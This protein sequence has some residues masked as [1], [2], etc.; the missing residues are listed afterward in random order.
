M[1][2]I[3]PEGAT[4]LEQEELKDLIP[5]H[6]TTQEELNAWEER[7][8]L[9]AQQWAF[10]K[11]QNIIS[12]EFI[13]NLHKHMF[14]K[15]W[16]WAGKFR[17]SEKNIDIS[18]YAI[19]TKIK[20]LCDDI[21]YYLEHKTYSKDEIAIRFHHRLVW[22]HAFPNGNG[23]HARL[24]ADLLIVKQGNPRFTWG[25]NQNLYKASPVR[26]QYIDALQLADRGDYS[27]LII[28]A[29]S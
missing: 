8:I 12:I 24:I 17:H 25:M 14:N 7:N 27:K 26:A 20:E 13:K 22:I 15:T 5:I 18:W 9:N 21:E 2:F 23:R 4:P 11:K 29:R 3:F 1:K 28:F 10:K 6:L 16:K 19:P